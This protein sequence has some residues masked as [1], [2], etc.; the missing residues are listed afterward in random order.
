MWILNINNFFSKWQL[1]TAAHLSECRKFQLQIRH[2]AVPKTIEVCLLP[3]QAQC[4]LSI[5]NQNWFLHQVSDVSLST[6]QP[7]SPW[8]MSNRWSKCRTYG[9]VQN[10][11]DWRWELAASESRD[12]KRSNERSTRPK[13]DSHNPMNE[14]QFNQSCNGII[15]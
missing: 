7:S 12:E 13:T 4:K 5:R 10:V 15:F 6:S 1:W 9:G 2:P 11:D 8:I 14:C 3:G